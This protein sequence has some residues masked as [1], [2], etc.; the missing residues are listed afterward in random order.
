[1]LI[2]LDW[3]YFF[4]A[5]ELV[6]Y[7]QFWVVASWFQYGFDFLDERLYHGSICARRHGPDDDCIKIIDVGKKHTLHTFEGADREGNGDF[8]LRGANY[9]MGK[10]SKAERILHS[11]DFLRGEHAINLG[12]CSNNV[13]LHIA[14]GGCIGLVLAH[15]SLVSRGGAWQ[16]V[17]DQRCSVTEV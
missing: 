16:M 6:H 7:V 9:G 15:V 3:M 10:H 12:T 11:T 4:T 8:G 13:G 2:D 14:C 5:K 17:F 1:M